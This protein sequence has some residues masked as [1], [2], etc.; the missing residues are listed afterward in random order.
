[1]S[2]LPVSSCRRKKS[3]HPLRGARRTPVLFA[4]PILFF[5]GLPSAPAQEIIVAKVA[6]GLGLPEGPLWHPDG[7]L[8]FS[9]I[10][11][12][13]IRRLL[14]AG[15]SA[16]WF[17]PGQRTN[18][19]VLSRDRK[20][21]YVC[22]NS[23]QEL[24]AVDPATSAVRVLASRYDGRPFPDVNDAVVD[25]HG[26]VFFTAPR[27]KDGETA[28]EG[29][30]RWAPDG[31]LSLAARLDLQPNGIG[32]SPDETW[33]YVSRWGGGDLWR[34]ELAADGTLSSGTRWLDLG[35]GSGPDGMAVGPDG[36]I[37]QARTG[38]GQVTVISPDGKILRQIKVMEKGAT[39]CA[40]AGG[41]GKTLYVTGGGGREGTRNGAVYRVTWP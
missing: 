36:V 5:L 14:P 10:H 15:G 38:D 21:L 13:T 35:S 18:G 6:D 31:T 28:P 7:Y 20:T 33:L 37:Y 27:W 22:G 3:A 4:L 16:P 39:N 32:L 1:M 25:R 40:L 29:I 12:A 17:Q 26:N 41:D 30:Y 19:L 9:D 2:F 24:L 23:R 34:F 8:I 11:A